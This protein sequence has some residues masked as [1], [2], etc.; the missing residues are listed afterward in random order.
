[1]TTNYVV[2]NCLLFAYRAL[3]NVSR[4][5]TDSHISPYEQLFKDV[6]SALSPTKKIEF[7]VPNSEVE[8]FYGRRLS[9][10]EFVASVQ[11]KV[12]NHVPPSGPGTVIGVGNNV[13]A[14]SC[15]QPAA[16][17]ILNTFNQFSLLFTI[18]WEI[19][20]TQNSGMCNKLPKL[21]GR[22]LWEVFLKL[23]TGQF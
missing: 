11:S 3:R 2:R 17:A 1:M 22:Q 8:K 21:S 16:K 6:A 9:E 12:L 23:D 19:V 14:G 20:S 15:P 5:V 10:V 4:F 18:V 7:S 13:G